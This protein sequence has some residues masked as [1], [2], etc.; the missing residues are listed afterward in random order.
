MAKANV[1]LDATM[2]SSLMSCNRYLDYRFNQLLVP[3]EGKS[4]SL[5]AGSLVHY[6]LEFYNRALIDGKSKA[7]AIEIGYAAGREYINGYNPDNKYIKDEAETGVNMPLDSEKN[8]IGTNHVYNTMREYFDHYR[9]DPFTPIA[10]EEVRGS[11]IYED[12]DIRIIWKAKFD[13]IIDTNAGLLSMDHKTAKQRRDSVSLNNQFM[14]Q[15]VLLKSRNMIID[16]IGFQTSL[17]PHEK[18]ERVTISYTADRLAEWV[19]DIVPHYARMYV[20]YTE[21]GVFPPNFTHCEN[22]YGFCMY[23]GACETD[24]GMRDEFLKINFKKGKHWDISND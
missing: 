17:K 15:C 23:K 14:G 1:V 2:L 3:K 16:K 21:A 8:L 6:I 18:F 13:L 11:L 10:A 5:E 19:N 7:D 9:N 24:R 20:A 22:K 4:N 12:D